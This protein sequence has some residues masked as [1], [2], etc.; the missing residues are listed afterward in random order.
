MA[1][2]LAGEAEKLVAV[3]QERF[4]SRADVHGLGRINPVVNKAR[5]EKIEEPLTAELLLKHVRGKAMV[6]S[7]ALVDSQVKW[8][9]LDIDAPSGDEDDATVVLTPEQEFDVAWESALAQIQVLERAG[10]HVHLERSRSGTGVHIWGFLNEWMPAAEVRKAL[11]PLL[12]RNDTF[13]RMYPVQDAST[14]TKPY[15]NLIALPFHGGDYEKGFSRF[16]KSDKTLDDSLVFLENSAAVVR[17]L[18]E[19]APR[20]AFPPKARQAAAQQSGTRIEMGASEGRPAQLYKSGVLKLISDYGCK[21]MQHAYRN[22]AKLKEP[23]WYAAMGQL[24][25]FERGRDAAHIFSMGHPGYDPSIVDSKYDHA[26]ENP[27][28]GCAFI[29]EHFPKF[30]CKACP[31]TAPYRRADAKL[32]S[33]IADGA[34]DMKRGGFGKFLPRIWKYDDG[35]V[36]AGIRNHIGELDR[37]TRYRKRELTVLGAQPSMGKTASLIHMAVNI[38]RQDRSAKVFSAE[39]SEEGLRNRLLG[40]VAGVDSRLLRGEGERRLTKEERRALEK[41][42]DE[43]D[44][45]P[46]DM[47]FTATRPETMLHAIELTMLLNRT[48]FDEHFVAFFDYIQFAAKEKGDDSPVERVSRVIKELKLLAKLTAGSVVALS[49]LIRPSEGNDEPSINWFKGSGD[50]EAEADVAMIITGPR[51]EGK[52][53]PRSIT[54]VKQRESTANVRAEFL[55]DQPTCT[56]EPVRQAQATE[57]KPLFSEEGELGYGRDSSDSSNS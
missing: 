56:F 22:R 45:M 20:D 31:M 44:H 53:A 12:I 24:T 9:A 43:L 50:I 15:G 11:K 16:Y 54:I 39:T 46:L 32:A 4:V 48:P 37:H 33:F 3:L 34:P 55:L 57:R 17:R 42:G 21:F 28:N 13:D 36:E 8:F 30:A 10:L 49:Q 51:I 19:K 7:Y 23:E 6:G 29:H 2:H 1:G 26:L 25:A 47:N 40:H 41:A 38:A 5:Y 52:T 14:E 18:A 35:E 27:P